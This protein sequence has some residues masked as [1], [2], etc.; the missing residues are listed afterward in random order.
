MKT[1]GKYLLVFLMSTTIFSSCQKYLDH[2]PNATLV[3]PQ[4][5]DDLQALM[6]DIRVLNIKTVA[7]MSES[8]ADDYFFTA[9]DIQNMNDLVRSVYLRKTIEYAG[10]NNDWS[11]SYE[12]VYVSNLVLELLAKLDRSDHDPEKWDQVKGSAYF[13]RAFHFLTL[14]AQYGHAYS[15][16]S[17]DRDPGIVLRE[18]SNFNV[19]STRSSVADGYH[20]IITYLK[21]AGD[22]LPYYPEHPLRP[23]KVAAYALLSRAYLYIADFENSLIYAEKALALKA[24]LIDFNGDSDIVET[25]FYPFKKYNKETIFYA[26]LSFLLYS[27][28]A[29]PIEIDLI[30]T[31]SE[32]DLRK[33][34]FFDIKGENYFF[35]GNYTGS[36]VNFGGITTSELYLMSA[37][38]KASMK[39]VPGAMQDLNA[40][41]KKRYADIGFQPRVASNPEE[42][43]IL[44]RQER[45][46]ELLTRNLRWMDIK[47]YNK[48]GMELYLK[49][50]INGEAYVTPPDDRI[51]ALPL[52]Q[53]IIEITGM[54]QN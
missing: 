52:P 39:D 47:R 42:A 33:T 51:Y 26:E 54:P 23:S 41:L 38:C 48:L 30:D 25:S 37:E 29:H 5:L 18:T 21:Q 16:E 7:G 53:D 11:R 9:I 15:A 19:K 3:V 31:Y 1:I 22:L 46:K 34:Y 13:F 6:D 40:L 8:Y 12:A 36:A 24:D 17:A 32:N 2:K 35:K 14:L 10:G 43:L 28:D 45:R 27:S 44:I 49:R 4:T 20:H 50:V